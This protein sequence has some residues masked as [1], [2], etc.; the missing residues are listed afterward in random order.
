MRVIS[1]RYLAVVF[2][3]ACA[4]TRRSPNLSLVYTPQWVENMTAGRGWI[5]LA[6]VVFAS[7]LPLRVVAAPICSAPSASGSFMPRRLG[8][9]IPS[10]FLSSTALSRHNCCARV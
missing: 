6:L 1:I 3:G 10:Q 5:A 9:G 7:W 8:F 2:G 4:G